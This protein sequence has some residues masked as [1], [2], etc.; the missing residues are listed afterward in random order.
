MRSHE[1]W[2]KKQEEYAAYCRDLRDELADEWGCYI[3]KLSFPAPSYGREHTTSFYPFWQLFCESCSAD[4]SLDYSLMPDEKV[5][6][7]KYRPELLDK[8]MRFKTA[9]Y[10]KVV[11]LANRIKERYGNV[12]VLLGDSGVKDDSF[13]RFHLGFLE[14]RLSKQQISFSLGL[15]NP[16]FACLYKYVL[17]VDVI[18]T[19]EHMM[20]E[21]RRIITDHKEISPHVLFVSLLKEFSSEE[22][23]S[24]IKRKEKERDALLEK[25]EKT[26]REAERTREDLLRCVSSWHRPTRSSVRCFSLYNYYPTNCEWEANDT[27]WAIRNLIW[28][29]KASP[30]K[31]MGTFERNL[32][33][34]CALNRI[35]P[36]IEKVIRFYFKEWVGKLTLLCIPSSKQE[37]TIRRY[38]DF[39]Q[40]VS[41]R[42][43][44]ANAYPHVHVVRDGEAKRLGGTARAEIFLDN[45]YFKGR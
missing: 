30:T 14:S 44:M 33:H 25:E 45:D 40:M 43:G 26:R 41:D 31:P 10:G 11:L 9:V 4:S 15:N 42:L 20:E 22:M 12:L 16:G 35:V 37:V 3:Y 7:E 36:D 34:V 19:N 24:L 32:R 17:V 27:E 2:I 38:E 21:C 23:R 18:Q 1:A 5:C 6:Y 8:S 39:S 28:D 13:N 29:F